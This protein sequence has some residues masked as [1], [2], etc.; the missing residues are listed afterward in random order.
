MA[1]EKGERVAIIAHGVTLK[2]IPLLF[3]RNPELEPAPSLEAESLLVDAKPFTRNP[4]RARVLIKLVKETLHFPK[5][6]FLCLLLRIFPEVKHAHEPSEVLPTSDASDRLIATGHLLVHCLRN[7]LIAEDIVMLKPHR[8]HWPR[9]NAV[10]K[11]EPNHLVD[12]FQI[13][14]LVVGVDSTAK[15]GAL[16]RCSCIGGVDDA[17]LDK[18][19]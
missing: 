19:W 7:E 5:R 17:P 1:E 2:S 9:S 3:V 11:E 10:Q 8:K 13:E 16:G 12:L 15:S 4:H 6:I 14:G 18:L